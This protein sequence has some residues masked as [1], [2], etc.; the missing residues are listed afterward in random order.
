MNRSK[1]TRAEAKAVWNSLRKPSAGKV[2]NKFKAAGR[3]VHQS[4][5]ARWKQERWAGTTAAN[6][7]KAAD[8]AVAAMDSAVPALTGDGGF[9]TADIVAASAA[10]AGAA[11]ASAP[12]N[13]VKTA[14]PPDTRS[15]AQR[16]EDA[17]RTMISGA[18]AVWERIHA[19]A[20]ARPSKNDAA[21]E[22][23]MSM[24]LDGLDKSMTAATGAISAAVDGFRKVSILR[25]EEAAAVPGAQTVYPPGHGPYTE[26]SHADGFNGE[27]DYPS[28]AA[29]EAIHRALKE[30]RDRK[31]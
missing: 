23:V 29:I 19:T 30:H 18:V 7:V 2:A 22:A 15:N 8:A 14:A 20:V 11:E 3:P 6:I 21:D 12:Q 26:S 27:Q 9:T 10:E 16:A 1:I 4:T 24:S 25:A 31:E 5:I 28:R 13:A 17:L